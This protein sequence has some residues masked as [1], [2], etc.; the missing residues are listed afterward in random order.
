MAKTRL[1]TEITT[2]TRI[3]T[4]MQ[5]E[6][7]LMLEKNDAELS[8]MI[9]NEV[10]ENTALEERR[11]DDDD[12][13]HKTQDGSD[14]EESAEQLQG[15]D[16]GDEDSAPVN[17]SNDRG[18]GVRRYNGSNHSPDDDIYTPIGVAEKSLYDDLQEQLGQLELSE[19]Q[20]LIAQ[21]VI[22]NIN[23]NGYLERGV[24][25]I[26]DDVTFD[27]GLEVS[28]Q[29][30][31]EVLDTVQTLEPPGIAARDLR[32]CILLQLQRLPQDEN[33]V[34]AIKIIKDYFK[35]FAGKRYEFL[36][37][38]LN[39]TPE[40]FQEIIKLITRKINP[41]PGS[42]YSG[43]RSDNS[44]EVTPDFEVDVDGDDVKFTLRNNI[45]ELQI[46][47]SYKNQVAKYESGKTLSVTEEREK[48]VIRDRYERA[49]FFIEVL[50]QRQQ[51]LFSTMSAIIHFQHD[52][53]VTGDETLLRPLVQRQVADF[54]GKDVTV[55]SRAVNN[56]YVQTPWGI[57]NLKWFFSEDINGESR[58]KVQDDLRK[59]VEGEDKTHPLSDTALCKQLQQMGYQLERRTVAKYRNQLN[60]PGSTHRKQISSSSKS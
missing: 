38:E 34:V 22:G 2:G 14:W 43:S 41:K 46:S 35:D 13:N 30:V 15:G 57:R 53:F 55:V 4:A 21:F 25:A 9:K 5:R 32:E 36:C 31:Q 52:Y 60:I 3:G 8:E 59:L 48:K 33:T 54:I 18:L 12:I 50:K 6:L 47:D 49:S 16:Y 29:Q 23:G 19:T 26:A 11:V 44:Q 58:H 40:R 37:S 42:A 1:T 20:Q 7:G 51:T 10:A 24:N 45:P 56:K 17:N 39:L 27:G 28:P